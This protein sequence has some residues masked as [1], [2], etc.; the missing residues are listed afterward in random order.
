MLLGD[1]C[2]NGGDM[3]GTEQKP[4]VLRTT[5]PKRTKEETAGFVFVIATGGLAV[6]LGG[7]Y[8]ARHVGQPFDVSYFG[9]QFFTSQQQE[10]QEVE[11]QKTRD[12]D[13]DRISDYDELYVLRTSPYLFDTDGDGFDDLVEVNAGTD[14]TCAD[15][16]DCSGSTYVSPYA[17]AGGGASGFEDLAPEHGTIEEPEDVEAMIESAKQLSPTE[18]R[19]LLI[20][21]GADESQ[22]NA[23]SDEDILAL[24]ASVLA[25]LEGT[26]QTPSEATQP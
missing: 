10:A 8:L 24:Y 20:S 21:A 3:N 1:L 9:P 16:A 17:E 26:S 4:V 18:I 7:F 2:Y 6:L 13:D 22:V 5:K 14:P 23:L 12:T 15:G 25:D 19:D 11:A